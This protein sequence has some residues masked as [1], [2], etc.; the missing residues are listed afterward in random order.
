MYCGCTTKQSETVEAGAKVGRG[1]DP[2]QRLEDD[3]ASLVEF[4]LVVPLFVFL[5]LAFID[6]GLSFGGVV[7]LRSEVNAAA[8]LVS[9]DAVSASCTT[10][11]EPLLC[12]AEA[13]I[14]GLT[15]VAPGSLEVAVDYSSPT[16]SAGT[17]VTVCAQVDLQSTTGI[18]G[19]ILNGRAVASSSELLAEQ[20]PAPG[21]AQDETTTPGF[22]CG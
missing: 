21:T 5:L 11:A 15:G 3:G 19:P 22:T 13:E 1:G 4:A 20:N 8:R 6:F 16:V 9:V 18:T 12:T 14:H 17:N 7:L 2:R 10:N